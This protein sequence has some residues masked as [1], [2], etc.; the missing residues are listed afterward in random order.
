MSDPLKCIDYYS[1]HISWNYLSQPSIKNSTLTKHINCQVNILAFILINQANQK[2]S[3]V[4]RAIWNPSVVY[5]CP[6]VIIYIILFLKISHVFYYLGYSYG[7]VNVGAQSKLPYSRQWRSLPSTDGSQI[8][9][10][11]PDWNDCAFVFH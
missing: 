9:N 1:M 11:V 5:T 4:L 10:H 6:L 8:D 3:F 2:N 7:W